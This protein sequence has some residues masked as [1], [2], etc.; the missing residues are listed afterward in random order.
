MMQTEPPEAMSGSCVRQEKSADLKA[1]GLRSCRYA[2][3]AEKRSNRS[4][5]RWKASSTLVDGVMLIAGICGR[6]TMNELSN[7]RRVD[8]T[9]RKIGFLTVLCF[10]HTDGSRYW[11]CRRECGNEVVRSGK[12]L[13]RYEREGKMPSCGCHSRDNYKPHQKHG[14]S[15]HR[16]HKIWRGMRDRCHNPRNKYWRHYGGRGIV[17]CERWAD[18]QNFF[19]DMAASWSPGLTLDRIDVNGNYCQE[20]CRWVTQKEQTRNTRRSVKVN[21]VALCDLAERTGMNVYTL[22]DRHKSGCPDEFL[23]L[24][25]DE[26]VKAK[27]IWSKENE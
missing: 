18:F 13:L 4:L 3:F 16:L 14:L 23:T 24:P 17:V 22:Y 15:Q 27:K 9:G 25:H 10:D 26:Y 7:F 6:E 20:N 12:N 1:R 21:G 8:L 11:K 2:F 19:D 5:L